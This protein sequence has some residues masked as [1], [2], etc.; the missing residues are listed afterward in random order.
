MPAVVVYKRNDNEINRKYT[1]RCGPGAVHCS[2]WG[3][4]WLD[5]IRALD[6]APQ[7]NY[8]TRP[9]TVDNGGAEIPE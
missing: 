3:L 7:F 4:S 5:E 1:R 9:K 6:W 2:I 8:S